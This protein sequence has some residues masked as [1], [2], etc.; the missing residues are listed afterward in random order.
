MIKFFSEELRYYKMIKFKDIL[1]RCRQS[2]DDIAQ[3]FDNFLLSYSIEETRLPHKALAKLE[4]YTHIWEKLDES[5]FN[6][7]IPQMTFY[8]MFKNGGFVHKLL[9]DNRVIRRP[10]MKQFLKST[11]QSKCQFSYCE[12]I[13]QPHPDFWEMRDVFTDEAFLLYSNSVTLYIEEH[14]HVQTFFLLRSFNGSCWQ[15]FGPVQFFLGLTYDDFFYFAKLI[16]PHIDFPEM[17]YDVVERDP[18][19]FIALVAG[20]MFPFTIHKNEPIEICSSEYHLKGFRPEQYASKFK[21]KEKLP[22]TRL[23]LKRFGHFPHFATCYFHNAHSKLYISTQTFRSF[24]RIIKALNE[25]GLDLADTP[26]NRCSLP[27]F[28]LA[29]QVLKRHIILN[30]YEKLF[31]SKEKEAPPEAK[32]NMQKL[33]AFMELFVPIFN[34]GGDMD[35]A[36][37]AQ[38]AG[39]DQ[40]VAEELVASFLKK[41]GK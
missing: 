38:Q 36:K 12:V 22:I 35:V 17:V 30:P 6:M 15:T 3:N 11:Q 33:N 7:I 9:N 21:I 31:N 16:D 25:N 18:A 39:L 19:P 29:Q 32:E 24:Q 14:E 4:D 27:M 37:L 10:G 23:T 8:A 28:E 41:M 2:S 5:V 26:D 20:A 1:S 13:S 40:G 34:S